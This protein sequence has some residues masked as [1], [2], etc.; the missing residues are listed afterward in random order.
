ML[1]ERRCLTIVNSIRCRTKWMIH[2][3]ILLFL[4]G[5]GKK[6]ILTSGKEIRSSS[7]STMRSNPGRLSILLSIYNQKKKKKRSFVGSRIVPLHEP[8]YKNLQMQ[9]RR[10]KKDKIL[11]VSQQTEEPFISVSVTLYLNCSFTSCAMKALSSVLIVVGPAWSLTSSAITALAFVLFFP[12][13][14][15]NSDRAEIERKNSKIK[16]D[17]EEILGRGGDPTFIDHRVLLEVDFDKSGHGHLEELVLVGIRDIDG[18]PPPPESNLAIAALDLKQ[19]D[20]V[21]IGVNNEPGDYLNKL[22]LT[23]PRV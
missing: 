16:Q 2:W 21:N 18:P 3:S 20:G 11:V 8:F 5:K 1:L 23:T 9:R 17:F 10:R 19:R 13:L 12:L 15:Y 4:R 6:I 7:V 22:R 14:T